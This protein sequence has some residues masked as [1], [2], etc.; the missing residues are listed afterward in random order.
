MIQ[1]NCKL[2][3]KDDFSFEMKSE[4]KID[5]EIQR[6]GNNNYLGSTLYSRNSESN[7]KKY[8]IED[9]SEDRSGKINT[10]SGFV[11]Q[12][13]NKEFNYE[14]ENSNCKDKEN[15]N[16]KSGEEGHSFDSQYENEG[17]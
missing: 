13:E 5:P 11:N 4:F 9:K 12:K 6:S 1:V 2:I 17:K 3:I 8:L 7:M 15:V 10:Q 16:N 14:D